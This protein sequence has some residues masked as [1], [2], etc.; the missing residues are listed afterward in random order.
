MSFTVYR[1]EGADVYGSFLIG[2]T[3]KDA[4]GNIILDRNG[5]ELSEFPE[6]DIWNMYIAKVAPG[7]HSLVIPLGS[8]AKLTIKDGTLFNLPKG[9]YEL[10]LTDISGITW[11]QKLKN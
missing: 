1:I 7:K 6:T 8:K 5:E 11:K 2:V 10:T 4:N 3:L 9:D